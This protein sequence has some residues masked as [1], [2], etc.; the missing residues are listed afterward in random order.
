ML[1][2]LT[3]LGVFTSAVAV[4]THRTLMDTDAWVETV[5]PVLQDPAVQQALAGFITNQLMEVI[6]AEQLLS[7]ALPRRAE[8][9]ATPLATSIR[10]FIY[11]ITLKLIQSEQFQKV[12]IAVNEYGHRALVDFLRGESRLIQADQ[13][14]VTA[15]V[16]PVIGAVLQKVQERVPGLLGGKSVPEIT[17]EMPVEE[18][19]SALQSVLDR[20]LPE[21][22]GVFTVMRSDQLAAL[23]RIVVAFDR[24]VWVLVVVTLV[25]GAATIVLSFRRWVTLVQL[26]AGVGISM[27]F[28]V[29]SIAAVKNLIVDLVTDPVNRAAAS[30]TLRALLQ[31]FDDLAFLLLA[32]GVALM[33]AAF[34]AGDHRWAVQL[35]SSTRVAASRAK[36]TKSVHQEGEAPF[37]WIATHR[38]GL[39]VVGGVV[40]S[41]W[42]V[43]V[44]ATLGLL[45][46]IV[47]LMMAYVA[48]VL[49]L[50]RPVSD[51]SRS[52]PPA[53]TAP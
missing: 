41:G 25:L 30:S 33:V 1:V 2:V 20:R 9:L 14:V 53:E 36:S 26:G 29:G 48:A 22:F 4:W 23:Q 35:R 24:A 45:V 6:D 10:E 42:L 44:D 21:N 12:W 52:G 37:P 7:G 15:N 38:E 28:A 50:S 5:G 47:I 40:A 11:D 39:L 49:F 8:F 32:L 19:R 34:L 13:G 3:S 18:Q 43:L 27:A 51:T 31:S 16:L 46:V 17:Y